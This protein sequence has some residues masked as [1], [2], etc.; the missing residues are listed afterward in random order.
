MLDGD[1]AGT[2]ED[3]DTSENDD[4]GE[5]DGSGAGLLVAIAE[6]DTSEAMSLAD[7]L[8]AAGDIDE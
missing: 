2:S 7:G 5:S 4:I 6:D 1:G 8:G 3:A